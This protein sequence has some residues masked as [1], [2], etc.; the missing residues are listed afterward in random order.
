MSERM[1]W[2]IKRIQHNIKQIDVTEHLKCSSTLISLYENNK[3]EMSP[4]RIE[5]YKQFIEG[6]N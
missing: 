1:D 4:E 3:G 5:R 6:N 2:K